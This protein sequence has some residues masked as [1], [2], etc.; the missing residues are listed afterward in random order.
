MRKIVGVG[1]F[2]GVFGTVAFLIAQESLIT[3]GEQIPSSQP[4]GLG[5][6]PSIGILPDKREATAKIL[7]VILSDEYVLYVKTQNYHWNVTGL[8]FH[9]LHG[10]FNK[11]YTGLASIV[12]E[13]AE[14]ARS[15]GARAL[16]SMKEFIEHARIK[17]QTKAVPEAKDMIKNLLEDHEAI[18]KTLR[19]D[20]ETITDEYQD[21]G[22]S[23]FLTNLIEKHEKMAWMLRSFL[24]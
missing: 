11:Q 21:I 5:I 6:E 23:N 7:N 10:F 12:D 9:D 3:R 13:V 8:M 16:G 19:I 18:I 14:R 2:L 4:K 24:A 22:T 1:L 17:E 20:I 15:L